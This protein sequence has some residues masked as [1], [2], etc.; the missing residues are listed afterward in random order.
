MDIN[1]HYDS[2][3]IA[4]A[5]LQ[6]QGFTIDFNLPI[7]RLTGPERNFDV[8]QFHIAD[9]YRYEG[10]SDPADEI[11]IYAIES[12]SGQRGLFIMAYGMAADEGMAQMIASL[13]KMH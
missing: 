6:R 12:V 5:E 8:S 2:A 1:F 11:I 10:E 9:I 4:I 7:N 3:T 13:K